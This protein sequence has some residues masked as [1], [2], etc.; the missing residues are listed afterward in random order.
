MKIFNR[1][2]LTNGTL[3]TNASSVSPRWRIPNGADAGEFEPQYPPD[4]TLALDCE[5]FG[6][7]TDGAGLFILRDSWSLEEAALLLAGAN[8][9]L[10]KALDADSN[11]YKP[12]YW[13]CGYPAI[14]DLL[15]NAFESGALA[16]P[17]K[18]R[19]IVSWAAGKGLA[20]PAPLLPLVLTAPELEAAMPAQNKK[21]TPAF[22]AEVQAYRDNHTE[23]QTAEK[24]GVSGSLIRRKLA[25]PKKA[26]AS[27][28]PTVVHRSK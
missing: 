8:P 24:F 22:I 10:I 18:P 28:F 25:T 20:I 15:T 27:L 14:H 6:L 23:K 5:I 2:S 21:W 9:R 11:I 13:T 26:K 12:D 16:H 19:D 7:S 4:P 1:K 17:C 3:L